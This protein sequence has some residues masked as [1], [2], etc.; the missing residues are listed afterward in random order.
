MIREMIEKLID[1]GNGKLLTTQDGRIFHTKKMIQVPTKEPKPEPLRFFTIADILEY[2]RG[3]VDAMVDKSSV[4]PMA[5]GVGPKSVCLYGSQYG[6]FKQ[7]DIHASASPFSSRI[8]FEFGEYMDVEDFIVGLQSGFVRDGNAKLVFK[9]VGN[10]TSANSSEIADDGVTQVVT[11][12]KGVSRF[13]NVELPNPVELRP[14]R[15]FQEIPQ[16]ASSYILRIRSSEGQGPQVALFECIDHQWEAEACK[17]IKALL[18]ALGCE[19]P[20]FI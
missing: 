17:E 8:D 5:F 19:I 18:L 20:I 11:A 10:L 7:R 6:D 14:H 1:L 15:T 16:P 3:A 2:S 4:S 12:R 13:I 9:V